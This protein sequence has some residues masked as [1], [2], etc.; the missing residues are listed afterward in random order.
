MKQSEGLRP[1][2]Y[3]LFSLALFLCILLCICVGS[4][5]IPLKEV[6][7][8]LGGMLFGGGTENSTFQ[9]VLIW[10]RIP[11]V[12]CVALAGA[13][14]SLC[15]ASM[16]GLL[17][18][19]LAD[20]STLGVSS[21]A[22]LGAALAIAL[23]IQFPF[24]QVGGIMIFAILFAFGALLLILTLAYRLDSSLSTDTIILLGIILSMFCS[25][26][27]NLVITFAQEKVQS[28]VFW[29]MGS[30]SDSN[31]T[32]TMILFS[33]LTVC[34]GLLLHYSTELNA[35]AIGEENARHVGVP[36]QRVKLM[37]LILCSILIGICVSVGGTIGFVG[38]IIPHITRMLTG[39]NHRRLLPASLFCGAV[40]LMLADLLARWL[41]RPRELPIG[42]VTSM[43]GAIVF[44]FV[45]YKTRKAR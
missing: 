33:V 16:Q 5:N 38:L 30:L 28:I 14:L 20:G 40:F 15:G 1:I 32:N 35:F 45:F 24:L 3:L 29:T 41:L 34:G 27:I 4:V 18:N 43:V 7:S 26:L 23:G 6:F 37:I 44:V 19:P 2:H 36:V 22:G 8:V 9:S 13:A 25:S 11:R 21:A 39:P 12:L 17:R 42:V 10:V 31:Y